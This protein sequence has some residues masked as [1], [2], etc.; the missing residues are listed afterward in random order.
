[1]QVGTPKNSPLYS[2]VFIIMY[3]TV[4]IIMYGTNVLW[5]MTGDN[6]LVCLE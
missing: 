6:V 4:F 2:T 3:G 1:M 5:I